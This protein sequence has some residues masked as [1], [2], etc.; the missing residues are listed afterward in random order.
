MRQVTNFSANNCAAE[1]GRVTMGITEE[2]NVGVSVRV[3]L[4]I[5][6]RVKAD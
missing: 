3:S 4:Q 2:S 1:L 6:R 5:S